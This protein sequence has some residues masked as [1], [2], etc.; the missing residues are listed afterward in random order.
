[1]L[2]DRKI[3]AY[4]DRLGFE[5]NP[6][7]DRRT[8]DRL[9]YLHQCSIPFETVTLH[10]SEKAPSLD[11]DD[12]YKKIVAQR[13]GGYCFELNKLFS[14]LLSSIGF[15][16]RPVLS[17]AVRG[18]DEVMPINH[19]GVL[20]DIEG[21]LYSADVGFG[22]PT[23]AGALLLE[24]A[25]EQDI[26]GETYITVRHD[27]AWWHIDRITQSSRD[28]YDDNLPQRRQTELDLCMAEVKEV[29]FE[30]LNHFFSSPG[31]LFRDHEI[32]N[33]R[34]RD[35]Y[36]GLKDGVLTKR[37]NGTKEV[38]GLDGP[39]AVNEILAT[40]FGMTNIAR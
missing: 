17:R 16:V 33:L 14:I 35:G 37:T 22:G 21:S 23:P 20:V 36:Y 8:L 26:N 5:G 34:T 9:V 28:L 19:R 30:P 39:D 24:H 10:R 25:T 32:A 6:H 11:V 27:D 2:A 40:L 15:E 38:V 4:L 12:L 7:A 29:D 31:L 13:F 1:M 3:Q 18:R